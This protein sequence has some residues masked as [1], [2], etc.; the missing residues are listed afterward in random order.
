MEE[1]IREIKANPKAMY[2]IS[3]RQFE[4]LVAQLLSG[5]GLDVTLTAQTKDGGR[6]IIAVSGDPQ[7]TTIVECK[8]YSPDRKVGVAELRSLYGVVELEKANKGILVTASRLTEDAKAFVEDRKPRLEAVD[9]EVLQDW[10]T[11]YIDAQNA[12]S[13]NPVSLY[14]DT[15]EFSHDDIQT[16]LRQLSSLYEEC[17]GDR[18]TVEHVDVLDPSSLFAPA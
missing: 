1:L 5:F 10:V 16:I 11:R 2:D 7:M 12:S 17:G 8:R 13:N 9:A 14:F 18:L 15:S 6:D 4:E 3:P